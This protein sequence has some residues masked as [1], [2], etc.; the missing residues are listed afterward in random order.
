MKRIILFGVFV[1]SVSF[2]LVG[3]FQGG[4]GS[5]GNEDLGELQE[6]VGV[7]KPLG[8]SIYQE[9]T[10]RL[11][12]D[13]TLVAILESYKF[14]LSQFEESEVSVSGK[15]RDVKQGSQKIMSVE[16]LV[17]LAESDERVKKTRTYVSSYYSHRFE[18]L[19]TWPEYEESKKA[20]SFMLFQPI[21]QACKRTV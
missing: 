14:D 18:Y 3:C 2:L 5:T 10:H 21:V 7:I 1:F 13:N 6:L 19:P 16:D 4:G 15:V 11:E 9:G 20:V 8:V 17:V 12:K